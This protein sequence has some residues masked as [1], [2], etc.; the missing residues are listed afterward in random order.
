MNE[1]DVNIPS[2]GFVSEKKTFC[3]FPLFC[4]TNLAQVLTEGL[5]LY[6]IPVIFDPSISFFF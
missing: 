2:A 5:S 3:F 6:F 4:L 1:V